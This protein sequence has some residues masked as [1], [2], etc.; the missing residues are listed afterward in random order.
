MA[1]KERPTKGRGYSARGKLVIA[2]VCLVAFAGLA[3][4]NSFLNLQTGIFAQTFGWSEDALLSQN[5]YF[6]WFSVVLVLIIG[7]VLTKHSPRVMAI[8]VGAI[9]TLNAFLVPYISAQWQY[10]VAMGIINVLNTLWMIQINSI[11]ISNWFPKKTPSIMGIMALAM[12]LGT[13]LGVSLFSALT[14]SLGGTAGAWNV[15]GVLNVIALLM[16]IF[17]IKDFPEQ[18]GEYP[19]NDPSESSQEILNAQRK[20]IESMASRPTA[21]TFKN[22]VTTPQVWLIGLALG[23]LPL[24]TSAYTSQM[25]PHFLYVGFDQ[26]T[27]GMLTMVMSICACIG[28]IACGAIAQKLGARKGTLICLGCA[29][30]AGILN[31]ITTAATVVIALVFVGMVLGGSSTFLVATLQ[32]YWGRF[33][34]P[35]AQRVVM[36]IQQLVGAC[37][38]LVMVACR[39]MGGYEFAYM[40]IAVVC[41][42]AFVF[43]FAVKGDSIAK[44]K[45]QLEKQMGIESAP[46]P[47]G[48]PGPDGAP[49]PEGAPQAA[50]APRH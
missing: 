19:D 18:C 6:G 21:W 45:A 3:I 15:F 39:M 47:E 20:G 23:A 46:M 49:A 11:F 24:F 37:G 22:L 50:G 28:S 35:R 17:G 16:V 42:I 7:S 48:F 32:E 26:A 12:A 2:Y 1:E 36:P 38:T 34:F 9:Y 30:I 10:T 31:A 13:G 27:A 4:T 33:D 29:V 43:I 41:A 44:R 14:A 40:V 5:S 8:V 25:F